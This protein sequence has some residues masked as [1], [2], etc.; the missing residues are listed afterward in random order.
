MSD[1]EIKTKLY[2]VKITAHHAG[3][4]P[5][6]PR[7]FELLVFADDVERAKRLTQKA[8]HGEGEY[9]CW[10]FNTTAWGD[11]SL[12]DSISIEP[13]TDTSERVILLSEGGKDEE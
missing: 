11:P 7:S 6:E 1:E 2:R 3:D 10:L 9:N 5:G 4:E 12:I 8:L 13:I